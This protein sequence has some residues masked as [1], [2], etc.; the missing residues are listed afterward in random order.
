[1]KNE[2]VS[3]RLNRFRLL[4]A[5]F[6]V[7]VALPGFAPP[8]GGADRAVYTMHREGLR[9]RLEVRGSEITST[10]IWARLHCSDGF[11]GGSGLLLK[12]P[13]QQIRVS[14]SGSFN[15][16][17]TTGGGYWRR[18]RLHGH[19]YSRTI[20]GSYTFWE[21][22]GPSVVCGTGRPGDRTLRFTARR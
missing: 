15:F 12:G 22:R 6:V 2:G 14:R 4:L 11:E 5:G 3:H 7:A 1:M 20:A 18:I 13:H 21:R 8:A 10:R 9:V 19:V 17:L 16:R